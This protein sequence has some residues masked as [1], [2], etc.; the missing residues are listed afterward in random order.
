[1]PKKSVSHDSRRPPGIPADQRGHG[2]RRK[3][4]PLVL[5]TLQVPRDTPLDEWAVKLSVAAE[6]TGLTTQAIW[7]MTEIRTL[8][9]YLGPD[10]VRYVRLCDLAES[11]AG[12]RQAAKDAEQERR[13]AWHEFRIKTYPEAGCVGE[14]EKCVV[15][16]PPADEWE[17]P[18]PAKAKQ[19]YTP[20]RLAQLAQARERAHETNR[21]K[22]AA[23]LSA[24][25][26]PAL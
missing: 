9:A 3:R 25:M 5:P 10:G 16:G 21:R 19:V 12:S 8:P 11:P 6:L 20:E 17:Q 15:C 1:L 26:E 23:K 7:K 18:V 4:A 14:W 24:R 2:G 13:V 22:R